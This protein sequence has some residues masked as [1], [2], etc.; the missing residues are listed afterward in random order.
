VHWLVR[1][2]REVELAKDLT[3]E[4]FARLIDKQLAVRGA[5]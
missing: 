3:Q 1:R 4:F 2:G 5:A